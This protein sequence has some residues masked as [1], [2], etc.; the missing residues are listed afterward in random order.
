MNWLHPIVPESFV[1]VVRGIQ[2]MKLWISSLFFLPATIHPYDPST[3]CKG[4]IGSQQHS[5][6]RLP[7]VLRV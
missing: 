2:T 4:Q 6:R 3:F 7:S 1:I 5:C